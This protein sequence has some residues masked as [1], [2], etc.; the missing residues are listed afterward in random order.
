MGTGNVLQLMAEYG[1]HQ[2]NMDP[3]SHFNNGST[4]YLNDGGVNDAG[5][6]VLDDSS[7]VNTLNNEIQYGNL[8][9]PTDNTIYVVMLPPGVTSNFLVTDG[10]SGYHRSGTYGNQRYAYAIVL[11]LGPDETNVVISHELAEAATDPL[12]GTGYT[13][14]NDEQ[15]V[16]DLCTGVFDYID[17]IAVQKMWSQDLCSCQ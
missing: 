16:G 10:F 8:P 3:Y 5:V 12:L 7:F 2:G 11:Y 9:F 17:G 13:G 4:V 1:V 14:S 6:K 15:E